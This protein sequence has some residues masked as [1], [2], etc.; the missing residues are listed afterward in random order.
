MHPNGTPAVV[1]YIR[2]ANYMGPRDTPAQSPLTPD[3]SKLRIQ[4]RVLIPV[5]A[6][7]LAKRSRLP[8]H[9]YLVYVRPMKA[10]GDGLGVSCWPGG[11]KHIKHTSRFEQ[12]IES[13]PDTVAP[14]T[15]AIRWQSNDT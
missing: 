3:G 6:D 10:A 8:R 7:K 13:R 15:P 9:P 1:P 4:T 5:P 11:D 12:L 2:R 14:F